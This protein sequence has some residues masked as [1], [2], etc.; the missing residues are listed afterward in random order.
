[1]L[2]RFFVSADNDREPIE[3]VTNEEATVSTDF[4]VLVVDDEEDFLQTLASRLSRRGLDVRVAASGEEALAVL[5]RCEVDVVVLDIRLPGMDGI[6]ALKE[7]KMRHPATEVVILTGF[8]DP[9]TAIRGMEL[10]AFDYL[11]KPVAVDHLVY[12][13]QDAFSRKSLFGQRT[14][15]AGVAPGQGPGESASGSDW[16][17]GVSI[18]SET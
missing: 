14:A 1:L 5:D 18:C 2:G 17:S 12:R 9:K 13:L 11:V 15:F 8:A 6:T 4:K 10:G 7:I 3:T 16:S